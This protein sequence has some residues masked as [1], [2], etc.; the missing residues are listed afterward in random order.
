MHPD[1]FVRLATCETV[2]EV[3]Q[4]L[5]TYP[6]FHEVAAKDDAHDVDRVC[7]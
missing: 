1:G 3:K 7:C 4:V 5:V 6:G 2:D